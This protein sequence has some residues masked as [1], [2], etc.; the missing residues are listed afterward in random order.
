MELA[1]EFE[2]LIRSAPGLLSAFEASEV[3][4][5]VDGRQYTMALEAFCAPLVSKNR[6]ISP[7]LYVRIHG[8]CQQLDGVDPYL[9]AS[10]RA[11]TRH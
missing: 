8:L 11:I 5:F 9:I 1:N 4:E 2:G 10:V 6:R 3:R 7:D